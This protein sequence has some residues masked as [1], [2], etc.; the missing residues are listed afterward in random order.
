MTFKNVRIRLIDTQ[1]FMRE[2]DPPMVYD[3]K[4]GKVYYNPVMYFPRY[5]PIDGFSSHHLKPNFSVVR[6]FFKDRMDEG[7][8]CYREEPIPNDNSTS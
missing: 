8:M 1:G 5:V 3:E 4:V 6:K 2:F 7:V